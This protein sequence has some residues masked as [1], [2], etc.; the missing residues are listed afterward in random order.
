MS[1][2]YHWQKIS[3]YPLAVFVGLGVAYQSIGCL[4]VQAATPEPASSAV[5]SPEPTASA[6]A[7]TATTDTDST[8][9]NQT[10][11]STALDPLGQPFY[12][13][14]RYVILIADG[15]LV[16]ILLST[17]AIRLASKTLS[18]EVTPTAQALPNRKGRPATIDELNI[19]LPL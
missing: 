12:S 13:D 1:G 2:H 5:A 6:A 19:D 10:T 9:S 3:L 17:L 11:E 4:T 7:S 8:Q 18:Q 16:L 14:I 15:I